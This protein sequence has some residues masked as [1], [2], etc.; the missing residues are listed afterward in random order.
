MSF[1]D[2]ND[3]TR[4]AIDMKEIQLSRKSFCERISAVSVSEERMSK[5]SVLLL[6]L[7]ELK[8]LSYELWS[9]WLVNKKNVYKN[10]HEVSK[11]LMIFRQLFAK[12]LA[13]QR[14]HWLPQYIYTGI[15]KSWVKKILVF[16]PDIW[17][18]K[19]ATL[20]IF[21]QQLHSL[22]QR[23]RWGIFMKKRGLKILWH[24]PFINP[25]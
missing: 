11:L 25:Y 2:V 5:N 16:E 9:I 12:L 10:S 4:S 8:G 17:T 7:C 23:P 19:S 22:K 14:C 1:L 15:G 21:S 24:S 3:I 18:F 20:K 13:F 6:Y